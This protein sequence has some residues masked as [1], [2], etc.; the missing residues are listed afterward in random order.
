MTKSGDSR[1]CP[2]RNLEFSR[3]LAVSTV[4]LSVGSGVMVFAAFLGPHLPKSPARRFQRLERRRRFGRFSLRPLIGVYRTRVHLPASFLDV[5]RRWG[6][7]RSMSLLLV[8]DARQPGVCDAL[9]MA[10][11]AEEVAAMTSALPV[12]AACPPLLPYLNLVI[13]RKKKIQCI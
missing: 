5:V 1:F 10:I 3:L 2:R 4:S 7:L 11:V 9:A 13:L 8:E 12:P 6:D